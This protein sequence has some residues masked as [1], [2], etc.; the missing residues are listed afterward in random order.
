M[1]AS[2]PV[3][4]PLGSSTLE[5]LTFETVIYIKI[6]EWISQ[7]IPYKYPVLSIFVTEL[8]TGTIWAHQFDIVIMITTNVAHHKYE[9]RKQI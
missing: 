7:W 9:R 4:K 6:D 2:W 8:W 1:V 5:I 3:A